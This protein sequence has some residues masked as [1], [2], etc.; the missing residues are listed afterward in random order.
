MEY[1]YRAFD[2]QA[3]Y[4]YFKSKDYSKEKNYKVLFSDLESYL[5]AVR[6]MK[7][8][9]HKEALQIWK[10]RTAKNHLVFGETSIGEDAFNN[11]RTLG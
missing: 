1:D 4:E 11:L 7:H 5:R 3:E 6:D 8:Y 10:N 2:E 9:F